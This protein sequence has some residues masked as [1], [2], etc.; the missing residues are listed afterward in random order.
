MVGSLSEASSRVIH[1]SACSRATAELM[2]GLVQL[3]TA[4]RYQVKAAGAPRDCH[5]LT[6]WF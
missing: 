6:D 4:C 1:G 3:V 5:T 2:A